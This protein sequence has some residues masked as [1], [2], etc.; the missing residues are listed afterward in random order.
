MGSEIGIYPLV[1]G[2]F[3]YACR[4]KR[5]QTVFKIQHQCTSNLVLFVVECV[6]SPCA[7]RDV[8]G[9]I[10]P[11]ITCFLYSLVAR[12]CHELK[13]EMPILTRINCNPKHLSQLFIEGYYALNSNTEETIIIFDPDGRH[14]VPCIQCKMWKIAT[15]A[16]NCS[17]LACLLDTED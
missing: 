16:F 9:E 10:N 15:V 8:R 4:E 2:W 3:S 12:K 14:L 13:R 11:F 6:V 17:R 1:D 7:L 5:E